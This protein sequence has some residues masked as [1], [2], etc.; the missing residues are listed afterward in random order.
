LSRFF[1]LPPEIRVMVYQALIADPDRLP[2]I[3]VYAGL[4]Q[5]CRLVREEF[6]YE[7]MPLLRQY[8]HDIVTNTFEADTRV[9]HT[10]P[11]TF[12]ES[13]VLEISL[14]L[15]YL[16]D[17]YDYD[18]YYGTSNEDQWTPV[19]LLLALDQ[20]IRSVRIVIRFDEASKQEELRNGGDLVAMLCYTVGDTVE[21]QR[22]ERFGLPYPL[23][24]RTRDVEISWENKDL[25]V[26]EQNGQAVAESSKY[27]GLRFPKEVQNGWWEVYDVIS[28]VRW[29]VG[30]REVIVRR[31]YVRVVVWV[32]AG[33]NL[34]VW[35][36]R[37]SQLLGLL[38]G[39]AYCCVYVLRLVQWTTTPFRINATVYVE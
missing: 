10:A 3:S 22:S 19:V 2:E 27:H 34:L 29:D 20:Q 28:G 23:N 15:D 24:V 36:L 7:I 35:C 26:K 38:L 8:Q 13:R 32:Q 31:K 1:D 5:S 11:T 25:S 12:D 6:D 14:P 18:V 4:R 21:G 16:A 37:L 9:R 30:M 17:D 33:V 39:G